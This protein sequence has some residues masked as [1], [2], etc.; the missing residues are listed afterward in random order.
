MK[1]QKF[2]DT[3]MF[4]IRGAMYVCVFVCICLSAS[5]HVVCVS[6]CVFVGA[7]AHMVGRV[8]FLLSV[9]VRYP[10]SKNGSHDCF[11]EV[12]NF[13]QIKLSFL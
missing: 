6:L 5:E 4:A 2:T 13:E 7:F 3:R 11:L 12:N 8:T 9:S 10:F 1:V